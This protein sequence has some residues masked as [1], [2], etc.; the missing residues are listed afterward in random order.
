[1]SCEPTTKRYLFGIIGITTVRH[2]VHWEFERRVFEKDCD[3]PQ[4]EPAKRTKCCH[5]EY[6]SPWKRE[7]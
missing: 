2:C 3:A 1:M 6:A 7:R 4:R 5:C